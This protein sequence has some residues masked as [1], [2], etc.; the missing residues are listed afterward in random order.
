MSLRIRADRQQLNNVIK[1]AFPSYWIHRCLW[2]YNNVELIATCSKQMSAS[3]RVRHLKLLGP[4][5]TD[6][7]QLNPPVLPSSQTT[8]LYRLNMDSDDLVIIESEP[9]PSNETSHHVSRLEI[10]KQEVYSDDES[11]PD[12]HPVIHTN[13]LMRHGKYRYHNYLRDTNDHCSHC[14]DF[15]L[16]A[17]RER[18]FSGFPPPPPIAAPVRLFCSGYAN[19]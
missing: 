1:P 2:L 16:Q 10:A 8:D 14:H 11:K 19:C 15:L 4:V 13:V 18:R 17:Y 5:L 9:P 7:A 12:T 3:F 6:S